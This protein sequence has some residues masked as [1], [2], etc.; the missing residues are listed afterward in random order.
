MSATLLEVFGKN[1]NC[2]EV[3]ILLLEVLEI[4]VDVDTIDV[5]VADENVNEAVVDGAAL[6]PAR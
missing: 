6:G 1:V 5:P 3:E 2:E 4:D